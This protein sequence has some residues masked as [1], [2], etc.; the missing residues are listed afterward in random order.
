MP[1]ILPAPVYN[2]HTRHVYDLPADTIKAVDSYC[3]FFAVP[4]LEQWLGGFLC[5]SGLE[6]QI[7]VRSP[8]Q[9]SCAESDAEM[10]V[11]SFV[12]LLVPFSS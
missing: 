12:Y 2:S 6:V 7:F 1:V 5:E 4:I 11:G 9:A 8:E 3:L 10:A